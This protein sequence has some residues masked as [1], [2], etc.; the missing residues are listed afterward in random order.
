[1]IAIEK[2]VTLVF[3]FVAAMILLP[4]ILLSPGDSYFFGADNY[5]LPGDSYFLGTMLI[6]FRAIVTFW[7]MIITFFG[8]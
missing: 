1:M 3:A 7:R 6:F 4:R 2:I 8:L 5:F